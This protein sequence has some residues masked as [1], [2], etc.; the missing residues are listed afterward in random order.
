MSNFLSHGNHTTVYEPP[1][2]TAHAISTPWI[3]GSGVDWVHGEKSLRPRWRQ[4][5]RR[6]G[7]L[8]RGI[9]EDLGCCRTGCASS[10][11]QDQ[12][13]CSS[14][15]TVP[16]VWLPHVALAK[17]G[18]GASQIGARP[19]YPS[20]ER[21]SAWSIPLSSWSAKGRPPPVQVGKMF[22]GLLSQISRNLV[23]SQYHLAYTNADPIP[24][25]IDSPFT[26]HLP[27]HFYSISTF[28]PARPLDIHSTIQ[29]WENSRRHSYGFQF[30]NLSPFI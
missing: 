3:L 19:L 25:Y 1:S 28:Y 12:H 5:H 16:L 23:Q 29:L 10:S 26:S 22:D 27:H 14:Q 21:Y 13:Y 9:L 18:G 11:A 4:L 6:W 8:A 2:D 7:V 30:P 20:C 17:G 24:T 15:S